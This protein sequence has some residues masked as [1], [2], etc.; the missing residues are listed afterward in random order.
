MQSL[1]ENLTDA[2]GSSPEIALVASLL[3]GI[4]SILLSPCHL[5]SIPLIVGY[6]NQQKSQSAYRAFLTS[7]LFST[8]ILITIAIIGMITA[9][10]GRILGDIGKYGTYMIAAVF[11]LVG[12]YF[13]DVISL[14]L[15]TPDHIRMKQKGYFA[16]FLLG[17]FF[18]I[19]LGPCTFAFM[20]P[21][22][23]ITFK[24]GSSDPVYAAWLLIMYGIGHCSVIVIAGTFTKWIQKYL[25]WNE[26]EKGTI[27]LKKVCGILI[28]LAGLYFIYSI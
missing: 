16:A 8:G 27:I 13:L 3:W 1:F 6:I 5:A 9:L 15:N 14:P 22:L 10:S 28:L 11:L 25:N 7:L 26:K 2:L 12:L 19:A 23:G 24:I 17:L 20:A 21:M 4:L 18:G